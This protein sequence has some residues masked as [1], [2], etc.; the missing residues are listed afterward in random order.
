MDDIRLEK[1]LVDNLS[2][3]IAQNDL[4]LA[5][6]TAHSFNVP[7]EQV[8]RDKSL[9]KDDALG[10]LIAKHLRVE[11]KS[12]KDLTID[13]E[14]LKLLPEDS[15]I[16]HKLIIFSKTGNKILV[17][18]TDP[19]NIE[20]IEFVEK[21][22]DCIVKP[23]FTFES[24]LSV[25]LNQYKVSLQD[26]F[27]NIIHN[28]IEESEKFTFD[29][30]KAAEELPVIRSLST[31]IEYAVAQKVS[32]IHIEGIEKNV[33]IR[34]RIDGVL[35]DM[36]TLP[37]LLQDALV[38]RVKILSNL[39][40]D[41][42][43]LP[44]DGR[45]KYVSG[46]TKIA[47]RVS[48]I[49]TFF[50]EN[51]VLRLLPESERPLTLQELGFTGRNLKIMEDGL[52]ENHGMIL[53]TGPTGSG[54][55]TTLYSLLNILNSPETKICTV[56]DPI[57][58]GFRRIS[59]I[60][61]NVKIGLTFAN[62]LRSLLRHDPD[63]IMVGEIR[64]ENT[65]DISIH[66]ALTGHLVLST[67]HTNDAPSAIPRFIDLGAKPFLISSTINL[68]VAQRLV[69]KI[70]NS[71]ITEIK[72]D[73]ITLKEVSVM[74]DMNYKTLIAKK[75]YHGNGCKKCH[76]TGFKGRIGIFEVL[77]MDDELRELLLNNLPVKE[78]AKYAKK[79]GMTSMLEDGYEKVL[80][81]ITTLEEIMRVARE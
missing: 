17:A 78:I 70:C 42:H 43:R 8:L 13:Q 22:T 39:K 28:N 25:V 3:K 81:K 32:D 37:K 21:R 2:G 53:V 38:A 75:Y 27:E 58:Y 18:M 4:K 69:R 45:F 79:K 61:V 36:I 72:P 77:E 71:C 6:E 41:E 12:L 60:Q 73:K 16:Y 31:I 54:K 52:Q 19:A 40:I 68:V 9:V 49:P 57:E 51:I 59:Q 67:L 23:Y 5:L 62:G 35:H 80:N 64:D 50:G 74:L 24:E 55:T 1:Y 14:V 29:L 56:E 26:E 63:I 33:I 15:A 46:N 20:S 65:A 11:Y 44:Q 66:S 30:E 10:K 76:K 48:I 34:F 7:F 47:L